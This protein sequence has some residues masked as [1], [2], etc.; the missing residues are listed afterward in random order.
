MKIRDILK[1]VDEIN[2]YEK[3]NGITIKDKY[4]YEL[5]ISLWTNVNDV[6]AHPENVKDGILKEIDDDIINFRYNNK[7]ELNLNS[8]KIKDLLMLNKN[9]DIINTDFLNTS[10]Y[11]GII[12]RHE[13]KQFILY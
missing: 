11:V 10:K 5:K 6:I 13:L 1:F 12:V 3:E 7:P 4:E 8:V 2:D 9:N